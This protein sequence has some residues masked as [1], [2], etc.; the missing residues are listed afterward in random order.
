[1]Q[2]NATTSLKILDMNAHMN[3]LNISKTESFTSKS[4]GA[5]IIA[6]SRR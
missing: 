3:A 1:M 6:S 2:N 4:A 5:E